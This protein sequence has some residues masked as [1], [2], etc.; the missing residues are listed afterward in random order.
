MCGGHPLKVM[1]MRQV[2]AECGLVA[3]NCTFVLRAAVLSSQTAQSC[4]EP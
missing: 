2:F 4:L 1:H 3:R